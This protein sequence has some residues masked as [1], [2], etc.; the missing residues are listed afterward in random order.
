MW[1]SG[2]T[3]RSADCCFSELELKQPTKRVGLVQSESH[4]HFIQ[5]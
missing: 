4:H 2:E 1:S 3:C 5:L